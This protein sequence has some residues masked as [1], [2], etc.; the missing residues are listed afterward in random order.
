MPAEVGIGFSSLIK[1]KFLINADYKRALWNAT[2]Q[3]DQVGQ[4]V[5]QNLI[6]LGLQYTIRPNG[7]KYWHRVQFRGGFQLDTGYLSVNNE[8]IH[9]FHIT[10][11]L[12]LPLGKL[13]N[14]RVNINY[15]FQRN[16]V[17]SDGLFQENYHTLTVNFS[18][19]N[20]WFIK[21]K[22]D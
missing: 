15:G 20:R 11:G 22:V 2:D 6:G 7:Y 10:A 21:R 18:F 17:I 14:S 3:Q 13:S 4:F 12:G 9:G 19:A 8:T 16:G 1:D 5:D